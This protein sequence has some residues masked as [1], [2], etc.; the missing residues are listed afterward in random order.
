AA[1]LYTASD[2]SRRI[3]V[4]TRR[5]GVAHSFDRLASSVHPP[6]LLGLT[7]KLVCAKLASTS[8]KEVA[9]ELEKSCVDSLVSQREEC[10]PHLKGAKEDGIVM[11]KPLA[12]LPLLTWALRRAAPLNDL[13]AQQLSPD[14]AQLLVREQG[15]GWLPTPPA[16]PTPPTDKASPLPRELSMAASGAISAGGIYLM[17]SQL[18]LTLWVGSQASPTFLESLFG[19][20]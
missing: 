15:D 5:L 11:L 18:E 17:D 3:R 4:S 9:E 7:T 20:R 6:A 16:Q 8:M 19:T 14:A 12:L 13:T 10:P 2:G 1:L